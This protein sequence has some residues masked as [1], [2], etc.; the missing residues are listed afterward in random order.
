MVYNIYIRYEKSTKIKIER[1]CLKWKKKFAIMLLENMVLR[2]G[3]L[4][5][6]VEFLVKGV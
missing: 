6:Y 3:K 1:G 4:F 2:I 5:L